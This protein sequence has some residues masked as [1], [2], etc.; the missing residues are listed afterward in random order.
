MADERQMLIDIGRV[1]GNLKNRMV[2]MVSMR[3][4]YKL[5]GAR[6]VKGELLQ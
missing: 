2:T 4:V 1:T 5:M 3:N 6:V